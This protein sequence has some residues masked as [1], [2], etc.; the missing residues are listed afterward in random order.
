MNIKFPHSVAVY[1]ITESV[2]KRNLSNTLGWLQNTNIIDENFNVI[3]EREGEMNSVSYWWVNQGKSAKAQ[4]DGGFLWAPKK[5]KN[6][7][8]F[9]HHTDLLKAQPGDIVFAYSNGAIRSICKV[10]K[11]ARSSNKPTSLATDLWETEGNL[12]EVKYFKLKSPIERGEIP[13]EWRLKE[14]GP[15]DTNGDVKQGYFYTTSNDFAKNIIHMFMD[16]FPKELIELLP[17]DESRPKVSKFDSDDALISHIH[18]YITNKG[19]YFTEENTKNLYLSL[20]TKPFV[21]LS[22]ISGTGKTKIVQLFAESVGATEENGQFK[23]IPVRPDW[24][25]GSDLIGFEDIRGD[26]KPG[27]L[28]KVLVEAN[29]PENRNK[30]YFILLDEMNL[31]R[32]EYYFSDLLSVMESREKKGDEYISIPVVDRPEVEIGRLLLRNNV[33]I[34]GTVNMDETTHPFSPKVLDRA[35]TIEYNDVQLNNFSIFDQTEEPKA[36]AVA[37]EQLAG[38]FI[39]LKDAF[40]DHEELIREVTGW[41]V[42]VN[43][44]LEKVK[45]HFGYRVRDEICFYMIYNEQGQLMPKEQV[46]DLQL[47]QKILPRISGNDADT[48]KVLKELYSYCTG[49]AWEADIDTSTESRFPQSTAKLASMIK[50]ANHEGFTSFWLG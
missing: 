12:L 10:I 20:K 43:Q 31:A 40:A 15:F 44:I 9:T 4:I 48:E 18:S 47:H 33:F 3:R 29:K 13:H 30:P 17:I 39:T 7:R 6:G 27:P 38:E 19:F 35:N 22:G 41:L 16:R 24:S 21:I 25:D 28:T 37:N 36:V 49:H 50:K 34:I 14:D 45:H 42:E 11:E 46:F 1:G 32:V 5:G 8:A 2:A 26:F 23:L